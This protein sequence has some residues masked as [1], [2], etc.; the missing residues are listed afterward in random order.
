VRMVTQLILLALFMALS[1]N[2]TESRIESMGKRDIFF[3]DDMSIFRN[4]A[5]IGVLGNF[6]TGSLGFV[7]D[8]KELVLNNPRLVT[9]VDT[10]I[11]CSTTTGG[12]FHPSTS[13]LVF[14]TSYQVKTGTPTNQW[15]GVVYNY[16][17]N[18]NFALFGGAAFNR[19]DDLLL[20]Y[21]AQKNRR[22]YKTG[23]VFPDLK[24]KSDFI[25]GAHFGKI[26]AAAAY[27]HASQE[28][29]YQGTNDS[30]FGPSI[31]L[32][33]FNG[34]TEIGLGSHSLEIFGGIGQIIYSNTGEGFESALDIKEKTDNSL[35]LGS[36]LFFQTK[37]GGGIVFVPAVN[38]AKKAVFDSSITIISGG[39]GGSYRLENGFFWC[40]MEWENYSAENDSADI[41]ESGQGMHFNFG[42]EKSLIWKWLIVRVGGHR[43]FGTREIEVGNIK[44]EEW[45]QNSE[46]SGLSDDLLGFGIGLNYQNRLR[47]DITFNE[48][49]PYFN[50]FG[51][52]L[53]GSSNGGHMLLRISSTFSL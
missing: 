36:R 34:G 9:S 35:Y 3:R 1:V 12:I 41:K 2:A 15:F 29:K 27:Y 6:V 49:T 20:F 7:S 23:T 11:S 46:D 19:E 4:P 33:R 25:L 32:N 53:E 13:Q 24:G 39:I 40:G 44:T 5:G 8:S 45:V 38:Y 51:K 10:S 30:T 21:N 50:P 37:I 22:L 18:P 28:A 26:N 17:L 14:D 48:A 43:Y 16:E 52:G 47:F 42:I 31:S